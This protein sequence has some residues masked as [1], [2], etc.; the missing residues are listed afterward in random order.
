MPLSS[1]PLQFLV[2]VTRSVSLCY[3]RPVL[4]EPSPAAGSCVAIPEGYN[5]TARLTGY[6]EDNR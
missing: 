1:V 4:V 5:Y 3:E 2:N 6:S